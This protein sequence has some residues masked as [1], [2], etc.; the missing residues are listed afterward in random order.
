[1]GVNRACPGPFPGWN[2]GEELYLVFLMRLPDPRLNLGSGGWTFPENTFDATQ[3]FALEL[4][5][6]MS[7]FV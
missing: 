4:A 5:D 7:T 1:M 3:A 6:D 2:R